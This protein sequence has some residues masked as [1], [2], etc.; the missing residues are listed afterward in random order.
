[1]FTEEQ[2]EL[3]YVSNV[4]LEYLRTNKNNL[5]WGLIFEKNKLPEEWIDEFITEIKA[6][7]D[8]N[9]K[10]FDLWCTLTSTQNL[11]LEWIKKHQDMINF[12]QLI[13]KK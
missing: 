7:Y 13:K 2:L 4:E 3:S 11:S 6:Q 12:N 10:P 9:D 5:C 1:M 8:P